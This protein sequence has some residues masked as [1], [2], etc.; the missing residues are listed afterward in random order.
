[1]KWRVEWNGPPNTNQ[2]ECRTKRIHWTAGFRLHFISNAIGPPPVMRGVDGFAHFMNTQTFTTVRTTQ[3]VMEA[4]LFIGILENAG[5]HP[6]CVDLASN[7]S[8]A[9]AE[10]DYPVRV[11]TAE[12]AEAREILNSYD[13]PAA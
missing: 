13:K 5:L 8:V 9:G 12:A 1:V 6:A 7:Y 10:I 3:T 2:I 11:P 4:G